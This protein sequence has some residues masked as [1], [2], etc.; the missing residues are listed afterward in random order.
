MKHWFLLL[1]SVLLLSVLSLSVLPVSDASSSIIDGHPGSARAG[2][3]AADGLHV[4]GG[5]A[6]EAEADAG[7]APLPAHPVHV[8]RPG[9]QDHRHA[10]RD[11]Q[12]R[13]AAHAG[14]PRESQGQGKHASING[15]GGQ[16][17]REAPILLSHVS[18]KLLYIPFEEFLLLYSCIF[19]YF[20]VEYLCCYYT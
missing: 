18:F 5:P 8:P 12:L 2:S 9:R 14:V 3:G 1:L 20:G 4:G 17:F 11:Q 16:T 6:S 19:Q 10:A 7:R 13:A 15:G